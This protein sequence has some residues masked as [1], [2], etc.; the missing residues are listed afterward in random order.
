MLSLGLSL[1]VC[2]VHALHAVYCAA[3]S[4]VAVVQ[5]VGYAVDLMLM[6]S[7]NYTLQNGV[8]VL[9]LWCSTGV[10]YGEPTPHV[11]KQPV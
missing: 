3:R 7:N 4:F 9:L 6:V 10:D 8:V 1:A 5:R 2:A 11:E